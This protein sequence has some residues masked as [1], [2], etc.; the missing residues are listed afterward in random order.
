MSTKYRFTENEVPHFIT[1]PFVVW[2][3][4]FSREKYKELLIENIKFCIKEKGLS[5]HAYVI[6]TNH[7]HMIVRS[8]EDQDLAG[9]I[10]DFKRFTAKKIYE[11]LKNDK[12]KA[13]VIG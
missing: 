8:K 3:D 5:I 11:E 6:M 7:V 2:I 13:D 9:I 4:L 12:L 10:R 1:M